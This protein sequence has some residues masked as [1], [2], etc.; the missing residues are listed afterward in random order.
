MG[1]PGIYYWKG[2]TTFS[3]DLDTTI[4]IPPPFRETFEDDG[5]DPIFGIGVQTQ[6]DGALVRLEYQQVATGDLTATNL[7]MF[8][9]KF[10]ALNL[11]VVWILR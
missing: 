5:A 8:D 11:S 1:A 6:L 10:E 9:N 4:D 7:D 2:Q 3:E